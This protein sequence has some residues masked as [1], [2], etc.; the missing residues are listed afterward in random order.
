MDAEGARALAR[1]IAEGKP[2]PET[3]L[4]ER[5][6]DAAGARIGPAARSPDAIGAPPAGDG[7][8][9]V[10]PRRVRRRQTVWIYV[11]GPGGRLYR[12]H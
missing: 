11:R 7:V 3:T 4:A 9:Y 1:R 10:R 6:T 2:P 5:L 12:L 8:V